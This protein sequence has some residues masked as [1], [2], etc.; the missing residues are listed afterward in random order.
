MKV[1]IENEV[2]NCR[3][4]LFT[5]GESCYEPEKARVSIPTNIDV[6]IVYDHCRK[7]YGSQNDRHHNH[8]DCY[9]TVV[10]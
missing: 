2:F 9:G 6:S 7:S 5:S 1:R 8:F 10:G 3:V 4:G